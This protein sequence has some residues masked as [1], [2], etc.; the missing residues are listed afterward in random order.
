[1]FGRCSSDVFHDLRGYAGRPGQLCERLHLGSSE[2]F[3][4]LLHTDGAVHGDWKRV[5]ASDRDQWFQIHLHTAGTRY[6]YNL[7][8]RAAITAFTRVRVGR[9]RLTN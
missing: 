5:L 3:C 4:H 2:G 1:M 6:Y 9:P 7:S 8:D